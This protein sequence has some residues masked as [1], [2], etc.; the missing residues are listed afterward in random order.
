MSGTGDRATDLE[1]WS[2]QTNSAVVRVPGR[3]FP[4]VVVQGD[5]LSILFALAMDVLERLPGTADT[6]LRSAAE[7]LAEKLFA[8]VKSY[9]STLEVRGVALP[10]T[11]DS[12]RVPDPPGSRAG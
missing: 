10:Y 11:P 3:R 4:G 9:E 12:Q 5:S 8:H 1:L 2:A 6:E 7:E